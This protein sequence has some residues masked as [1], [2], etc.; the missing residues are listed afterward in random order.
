MRPTSPLGIMPIPTERRSSRRPQAP[1]EQACLPTT[2]ATVRSREREHVDSA[3][4]PQVHA[5]PHDDEE[6]RD[7][8]ARDGMDEAFE[9]LFATRGKVAKVHF[10]EN[11]ACC[12]G[13]DDRCKAE[14]G[15]GIGHRKADDERCRQ[16]HALALQA[17]GQ[18]EQARRQRRPG[19]F[20]R[21]RAMSPKEIVEPR[22]TA[23]IM[24]A[25]TARTTSP[26]IS[27]MTAAPRIT[28]ASS[29]RARP[30]S[31]S[32]RAVMPTLVAVSVAP[33]KRWT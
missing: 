13:T 32:T 17:R 28:R 23:A 25:T 27:S 3:E 7:E 20:P 9:L 12:I 14:D 22:S 33:R 10:L 30:R 26:R 8:E 15:C 19:T 6:H 21:M 5:H 18:A 4:G 24:P 16:E 2:A 29:E 1:I 11:Q 31:V